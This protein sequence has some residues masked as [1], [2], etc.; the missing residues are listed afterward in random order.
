MLARYVNNK[1]NFV[2]ECNM[3]EGKKYDEKEAVKSAETIYPSVNVE[4]TNLEANVSKQSLVQKGFFDDL[5]LRHF[6]IDRRR[7]PLPPRYSNLVKMS[8]PCKPEMNSR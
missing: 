8:C 3:N 6:F 2:Q 1:N 5:F 7:E 4:K